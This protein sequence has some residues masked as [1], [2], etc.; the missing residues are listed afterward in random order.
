VRAEPET[1]LPEPAPWPK[2]TREQLAAVRAAVLALPRLWTLADVAACFKSRGRYRE[3]IQA[4][5]DLLADLGG[6]LAGKGWQPSRQQGF[7]SRW[8]GLN[9]WAIRR[10]AAA[11]LGHELGK[12]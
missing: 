4:H 12:W 7:R 9:F 11:T 2:E 1:A 8:V 3:S 5:L 10:M 6:K